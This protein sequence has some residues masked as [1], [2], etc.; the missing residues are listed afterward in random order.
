M[1]VVSQ[2]LQQHHQV[3]VSKVD[4]PVILQ[5]KAILLSAVFQRRP[6]KLIFKSKSYTITSGRGITSADKNTNNVVIESELA[7]SNKLKVGD[8][9]KVKTTATTS[10]TYEM[11]IVGIYKAKTTIGSAAQ[12]G[13]G[14]QSDPSNT[15]FSSYTF[16]GTVN[17][18]ST[19]VTSVVYTLTDSLKGSCLYQS[20]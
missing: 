3:V 4:L 10:K 20:R 12:G 16:A 11:K 14:Q 1:P 18:D 15:I 5:P 6:P 17:G 13:P 8:T 19:T 7:T 9:I 2:R